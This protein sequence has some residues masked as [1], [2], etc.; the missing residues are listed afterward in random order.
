MWSTLLV[1]DS[2]LECSPH[3]KQVHQLKIFKKANV[4]FFKQVNH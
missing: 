2:L 4:T 3:L 1:S